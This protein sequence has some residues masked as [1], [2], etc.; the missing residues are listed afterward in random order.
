MHYANLKDALEDFRNDRSHRLT[1]RDG[2]IIAQYV[3]VSPSSNTRIN[4]LVNL[5]YHAGDL[6]MEEIKMGGAYVYVLYLH[7][8]NRNIP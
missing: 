2:R 8:P 1:F 3:D 5:R 6:G 4:M 7:V